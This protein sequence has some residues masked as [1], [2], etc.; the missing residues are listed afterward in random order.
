MSVSLEPR[1]LWTRKRMI[2]G[3][4]L[5][6]GYWPPLFLKSLL[7]KRSVVFNNHEWGYGVPIWG[8][9]NFLKLDS[10][11]LY[12]SGNVQLCEYVKNHF[13]IVNF[14]VWGF[15]TMFFP[16]AQPAPLTA[17]QPDCW[18]VF[19]MK[20][21]QKRQARPEALPGY[22][23]A[24]CWFSNLTVGSST[25]EQASSLKATCQGVGRRAQHTGQQL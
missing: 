12:V 22:E 20:D 11:Q 1:I 4:I 18:N 25:S 24:Q 23:K 19:K 15:T 21:F 5:G 16:S 8:F 17:M 7:P 14:M 13:K 2:W 9:E 10:G 3:K 6:L